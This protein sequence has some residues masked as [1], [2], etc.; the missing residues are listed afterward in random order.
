MK[1]FAPKKDKNFQAGK[2]SN[3]LIFKC[4]KWMQ[5]DQKKQKFAQVGKTE[6]T[7][8]A[9]EITHSKS[10]LK[11]V[12][13]RDVTQWIAAIEY[14]RARKSYEQFFNNYDN[15]NLAVPKFNQN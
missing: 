1:P 11:H 14:L 8:I 13:Q 4:N 6:I 15:V 5:F 2:K 12:Q 9:P 10:K 3:A 7:L